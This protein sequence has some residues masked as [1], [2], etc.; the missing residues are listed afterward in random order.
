MAERRRAKM[1]AA[2]AGKGR[3]G[4]RRPW[5]W[6]DTTEALTALVRAW[7]TTVFAS[8][9]F[10]AALAVSQVWD[11]AVFLHALRDALSDDPQLV[12]PIDEF[13]VAASTDRG[14]LWTK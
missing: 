10:V 12:Q 5:Q 13:S 9:L 4:P 7:M 3:R 6:P 1:L 2:I 14:N 11:R 8:V